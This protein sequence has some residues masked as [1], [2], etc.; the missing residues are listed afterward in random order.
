M[1]GV[2][3]AA[4][5]GTRAYPYTRAIPKSMLEVAGEPNLAR[6]IAIMRDQLDI[7]DIVIIIGAFGDVITDY[8]GDGSRFGV[9]LTYVHN[10]AI[11]KGLSY[12]ILLSRPHVRDHFCVILGDECYLDS[13]HRELLGTDYR[14]S[15][16]TCAV[17]AGADRDTIAENYAVYAEGERVRRVVEKPHDPGD[18]LLGL[19]TFLFSPEFYDHLAAAL[20]ANNGEPT[21]PVSVLGRLCERGARVTAFHMRG[22]YVNINGRDALNL[23]SNLVRAQRFPDS[24]FAVVLLLKGSPTSTLRT[25][26]EFRRTLPCR[27]IV[28]VLPPEAAPIPEVAGDVRRVVALSGGYGDMMRAGLDAA[29]ADILITAHSDGSCAPDDA[30]K[31]LVYLKDADIVVGTRTTRQLIHQGTN[32][33]GIVRLAHVVLAKLLEL[34][35]W[36]YEPRFTDL[37]CAYRAIWRSTY[38]ILRPILTTSGPE[39]A[40]EML[41]EALKCRKRIIEIPVSYPLPRRGVRDRDQ[42]L[43]TFAGLLWT[44]VMRRFSRAHR[45]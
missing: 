41:V 37:G 8:F 39:Y 28:L 31:F 7:T 10:D 40:V 16:A 44:I 29:D 42:T 26:A 17:V 33:R 38:R 5:R 25:V 4:G 9:R 19:G 13:N 14:G 34:F 21:D 3:P 27:E 36:S 11:D 20:A 43:A 32:M 12:S 30:A 35:W 1:I 45:R 23:A 24:T 22:R 18:A 2:I 15:L 6:V